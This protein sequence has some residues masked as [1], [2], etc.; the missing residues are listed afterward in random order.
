M[1]V[2]TNLDITPHYVVESAR[3]TARDVLEPRAREIPARGVLE[4]LPPAP[5]RALSGHNQ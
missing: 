2:Y 4:L 3:C 1:I 5:L